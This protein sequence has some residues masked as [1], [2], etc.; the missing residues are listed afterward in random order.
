MKEVKEDV[1]GRRWKN[2]GNGW[3]MEGRKGGSMEG[4]VERNNTGERNRKRDG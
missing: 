4:I 2:R 3:M 1:E